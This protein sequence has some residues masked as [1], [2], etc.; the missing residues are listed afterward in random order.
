M[1]AT[2]ALE[3][4]R[5]A[6]PAFTPKGIPTDEEIK[7]HLLAVGQILQLSKPRARRCFLILACKE[8]SPARWGLNDNV[9]AAS[10]V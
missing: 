1:G 2:L 8:K 4:V 7:K 6:N 3:S 9:P 10:P 5:A